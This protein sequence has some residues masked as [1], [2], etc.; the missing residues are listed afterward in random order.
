MNL[1]YKKRFAWLFHYPQFCSFN[2]QI[3]YMLNE[4]L[5]AKEIWGTGTIIRVH[6]HNRG[7]KK[8]FRWDNELK[9]PFPYFDRL[10]F[11]DLL[12]VDAQ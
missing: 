11:D 10:I 2:W 12:A 8:M 7:L 3:A 6:I 5:I 9:Y 4:K 1:R